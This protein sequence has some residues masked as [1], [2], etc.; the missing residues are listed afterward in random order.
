MDNEQLERLQKLEKQKRKQLDR[1][2]KYVRENYD[3]IG[4]ALPKGQKAIIE[5]RAKEKGYKTI[6]EYVKALIDQ[7]INGAET[8]T[9]QDQNCGFFFE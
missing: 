2:N 9:E 5:N 6:T 3:R 1:Q 8:S 4:V 7:D